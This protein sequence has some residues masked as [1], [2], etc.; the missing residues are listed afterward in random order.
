MVPVGIGVRRKMEETFNK[1]LERLRI[2]RDFNNLIPCNW[3]N[4]GIMNRTRM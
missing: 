3:E 1:D 2:K 4:G